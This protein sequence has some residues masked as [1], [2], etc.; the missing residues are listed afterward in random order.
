MSQKSARAG[1]DARG[2]G[3]RAC[4]LGEQVLAC[5][6]NKQL[7]AKVLRAEKGRNLPFLS[8]SLPPCLPCGRL[9]PTA[10]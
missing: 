4:A 5:V 3:E 9:S 7:F 6:M 1:K 8:P 10:F 2:G